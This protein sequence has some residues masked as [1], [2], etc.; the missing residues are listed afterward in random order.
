MSESIGYNYSLFQSASTDIRYALSGKL[1]QPSLKNVMN[2]LQELRI[3]N[4]LSSTEKGDILE[5]MIEFMEEEF[6]KAENGE[7]KFRKM[8]E[9]PEDAEMKTRTFMT[10]VLEA[11]LQKYNESRYDLLAFQS[12]IDAFHSMVVDAKISDFYKRSLLARWGNDNPYTYA[13]LKDN[14]PNSFKKRLITIVRLPV[15]LRYDGLFAW[16][17]IS[18]EIAGHHF[19]SSFPPSLFEDIKGRVLEKLKGSELIR[20]EHRDILADYWSTCSLELACDVLGV[21]NL[22]PAFAIGFAGYLLGTQDELE[23]SGLLHFEKMR[24]RR[25]IELEL[26]NKEILLISKLRPGIQ[27]PFK[28]GLFGTGTQGNK[29]ADVNFKKRIIPSVKYPLEI[30]RLLAIRNYIQKLFNTYSPEDVEK[31][32]SERIALSILDDSSNEIKKTK[33]FQFRIPPKKIIPH[34]NKEPEVISMSTE[35]VVKSAEIAAQA[36]EDALET[37][38]SK[39]KHQISDSI[40]WK[41]SDSELVEFLKKPLIDEKVEDVLFIARSTFPRILSNQQIIRHILA[42]SI[43]TAVSEPAVSRPYLFNRMKDLVVYAGKKAEN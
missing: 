9:S 13:P 36:V 12:I 26:P 11:L 42:A 2:V 5:P 19:L 43:M 15:G 40:A 3:G 35:D 37:W 33:E 34:S 23:T 10:E 21:W 17:S 38:F 30:L 18:H 28:S 31:A 27:I 7:S 41:R 20:T 4:Q 29:T 14:V 24:S 1:F 22:G 39:K 8:L 6:F 16:S 25:V 32:V